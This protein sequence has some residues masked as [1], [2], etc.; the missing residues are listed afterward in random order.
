MELLWER[1][2]FAENVSEQTT[3]RTCAWRLAAIDM[4]TPVPQIRTPNSL[5]PVATLLATLL[6]ALLAAFGDVAADDLA[7]VLVL[8]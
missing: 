3:A 2:N 1:L 6:A 5:A 4:P 7:L 8:A